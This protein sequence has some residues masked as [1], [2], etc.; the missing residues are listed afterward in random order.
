MLRGENVQALIGLGLTARQA[1]VYFAIAGLEKA[2]IKATSKIA[3]IA[4]QDIYRITAELFDLGLIEKIIASPIEYR[5]MPIQDGINIL[6]QRKQKENLQSY[7]KAMQLLQRNK[8][9]N[10]AMQTHEDSPQFILVPKEEATRRKFRATLGKTQRS[11][12]GILYWKGFLEVVVNGIERWK[13]SLERGVKIRLIVYKPQ[14]EKASLKTIQTL[15]KKG[16]FNIRYTSS[17]PPA[18]LTI[19]DKE[20]ILGT[21]SPTPIPHEVPSLWIN[22]SS[23]VA[24]FQDYFERV[25]LTS[26]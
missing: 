20:K 18:S 1:R 2:T 17:P 9:D 21:T 4:R 13:K 8:D 3:D 6:L 5:A 26:K 23:I 7:E 15:K 25:W 11:V 22:N 12:D 10:A 14:E 19:F 16:S 24:I